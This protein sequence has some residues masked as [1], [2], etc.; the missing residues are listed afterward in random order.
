MAVDF[1]CSTVVL[2]GTYGAGK[3]A[4]V[5]EY[6]KRLTNTPN[7]KFAAICYRR[8]QGSDL[9]GKLF[10]ACVPV[11]FYLHETGGKHL[12][13]DRVLVSTQSLHR[14]CPLPFYDVVIIDE[15]TSLL[16]DAAGSGLVKRP[17]FDVL[18]FL[19]RTA[20]KLVL[21]D[22]NISQHLLGIIAELRGEFP[23]VAQVLPKPYMNTIKFHDNRDL[24]FARIVA[25][26][27]EGKNVAFC[28]DS[29]KTVQVLTSMI[30][31]AVKK[32]IYTVG[33]PY[34]SEL[35]QVDDHWDKFQFVAYSPCITTA[36]SF[37]KPH[38]DEMYGAFEFTSLSARAFAQQ[39]HRV[40]DLRTRT[41]HVYAASPHSFYLR[42]KHS[43]PRVFDERARDL[44]K[45]AG[46]EAQL[47]A[48]ANDEIDATY[49]AF[50]G[51]LCA[52]IH[53]K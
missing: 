43:V 10:N 24:F 22:V 13:A 50:V 5:C 35:E 52:A 3:S 48:L 31:L 51:E 32:R 34:A 29:K 28:S 33:H 30:P 42:T 12:P 40:R 15:A 4:A 44:V 23:A 1:D 14:I 6:L 20:P 9:A 46:F 39:L 8:S 19:V 45:G 27:K 37:T 25:R 47:R 41:V 11:V 38:F 53:G 36:T 26:L 16:F 49:K 21:M 2:S 7:T 18:Q 17:Q